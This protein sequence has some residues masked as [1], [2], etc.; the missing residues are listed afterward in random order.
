MTSPAMGDWVWGRGGD[1]SGMDGRM[2]ETGKHCLS[3]AGNIFE[4]LFF[5]F[6]AYAYFIVSLYRAVI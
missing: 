2:L 4:W 5:R 3:Q 1:C 6:N